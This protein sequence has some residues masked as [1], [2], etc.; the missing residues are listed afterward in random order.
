MAGWERALSASGGYGD[1]SFAK[2]GETT[3]S[4]D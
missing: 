1:V 2:G 4:C 3:S